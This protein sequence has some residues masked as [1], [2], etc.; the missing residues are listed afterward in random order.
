MET[1][2]WVWLGIIAVTVVIEIVTLDLVSIWFAFGAVIPFILAAVGGIALEIQIAVFVAVSALLIIFLRK[3]AQKLLFKNMNQKTNVSA[4]E[5]KRVRLLE[6]TDFEH[7]GSVKINDIVWTAVSESGELIKAG[8]L[9]E[10]ERVDGNKLIVKSVANNDSN[11]QTVS[12]L[13]TTN[14]HQDEDKS[15]SQNSIVGE[16][17]K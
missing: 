12:Q 11:N 2:F 3:S 10:I 9:V 8:E 7:N 6:D 17:K 15:K 4:L 5:G 13:E 16:D 1:M 14:P